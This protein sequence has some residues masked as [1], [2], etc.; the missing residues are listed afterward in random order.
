MALKTF[1]PTSPSMRQLVRVDRSQ[2]WKG[3]PL[4]RLT[5]GLSKTGGRN[6]HGRITIRH[7]GGGHKRSYRLIDFRRIKHDMPGKVERIEYDPNRT[8]Y[9]ATESNFGSYLYDHRYCS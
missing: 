1:N 9:I 3:G 4:K 8:A 2:L 5:E 6:H 7:I